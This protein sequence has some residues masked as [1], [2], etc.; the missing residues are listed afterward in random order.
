MMLEIVP[1]KVRLKGGNADEHRFPGYDGYMAMAGIS[2]ILSLTAN[3]VETSKVRQRGDFEGRKLV[4]GSTPLQGSVLFDLNVFLSSNP[5]AVFGALAGG[6]GAGTLLTLLFNRVLNRNLGEKNEVV[7]RSLENFTRRKGGDI[8]ALVAISEPAIRQAHQVIGNGVSKME[9]VGGFR[10]LNTF[11][12][13]TKEYV[14]SS[15]EDR[16]LQ[17]GYFSVS[18]FNA[19]SGYGSVFDFD[20]G[21]SVP[22]RMDAEKLRVFKGDFSWGL[23]QYATNKPGKLEIVFTRILAMDKTPKRYN[24]IRVARLDD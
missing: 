15:F 21:R 17:K 13:D 6:L 12:K 20:L 5:Q 11:D 1:F 8:E 10:I 4:Q 22:F 14:S 16:A 2:R 3:Y 24:I 19:N 9:I 18:A 7:D 23:D